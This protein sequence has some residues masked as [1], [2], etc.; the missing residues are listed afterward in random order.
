MAAALQSMIQFEQNVVALKTHLRDLNF[1][2]KARC[3]PHGQG[4]IV[5]GHVIVRAVGIELQRLLRSRYRHFCV[6]ILRRQIA[7]ETDLF[8]LGQ[9]VRRVD[10]TRSGQ[11][12]EKKSAGYEFSGSGSSRYATPLLTGTFRITKNKTSRTPVASRL[13]SGPY[14]P[15]LQRSPAF[16]TS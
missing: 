2:A 5:P 4:P 1:V 10:D 11:R 15:P 7:H 13:A 12:D 9:F 16:H 8:V 3:L 14:V 6:R